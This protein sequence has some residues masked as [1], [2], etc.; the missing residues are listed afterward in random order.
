MELKDFDS[1]YW[2][3]D[4]AVEKLGTDLEE[5]S[6]VGNRTILRAA[7][8]VHWDLQVATEFEVPRA[9][10]VK[11]PVVLRTLFGHMKNSLWRGF[12]RSIPS[13]RWD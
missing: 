10:I 4:W 11:E 2:A 8:W 6:E 9:W 5:L 1:T 3:K 12:V 13:R 7:M